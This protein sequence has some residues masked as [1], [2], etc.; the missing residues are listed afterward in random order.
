MT[1]VVV[2]PSVGGR[3]TI[4]FRYDPNVVA[5]IK[6]T[7]PGYGRSW[8]AQRRVWFVEPDWIH[9][10]TSELRRRGHTVTGPEEPPR[11]SESESETDWAKMLFRRVGPTRADPC[12]RA[13]ARILHPDVATG[14]TTLMRE[15]LDARDQLTERNR[16]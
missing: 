13:L 7:V 12:F 5:T 14:D 15:L 6:Q 8:D 9:V 2:A 1:A 4:R 11:H 3:Y 16:S 10:L